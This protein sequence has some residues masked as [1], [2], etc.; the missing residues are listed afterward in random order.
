MTD[1]IRIPFEGDEA[2]FVAAA[3][4]VQK[5]M[6]S[7]DA[8]LKAAGVTQTAYNKAVSASVKATTDAKKAEDARLATMQKQMSS[9]AAV[10]KQK[11]AAMAAEEKANQAGKFSFTELKSAIDLAAQAMQKLK[12]G[13]D[14]AREGASIEFTAQKFDRLAQTI[15]T[16]GDALQDK[17]LVATKGTLSEMEAMASATDLISLG[18]VKTE[19]DT[20]RL[21]AVVAGLGMD[22]NQ[23][24]LALSN[25][26]TMRFDQ[27]GVAVVGF[28]EKVK[29]L[30][31]TGMSAQD[32]FTEA[33]LQ[34][35]EE[36]LLKVGNAADTSL[37]QFM[38]MEAAVKDLKVEFNQFAAALIAPQ[39]PELTEGLKQATWRVQNFAAVWDEMNRLRGEGFGGII[40]GL[41]DFNM[42][43]DQAEKNV[44][45]TQQALEHQ[46]AAVEVGTDRWDDMNTV[47]ATTTTQLPLTEEQ[48]KAVSEANSQFLGVL[49]NVKDAQEEFNEGMEKAR[50]EWHEG[51]IETEEYAAKVD[52]LRETYQEASAAIVMSIVEMKLAQDGWTNAELDAY[53]RIG[54]AQGVFTQGQVEM[55]KDALANADALIASSG[56]LGDQ[57]FHTGERAEDA[58]VGMGIMGD[59]AVG[60]QDDV[61]PATAA[62]GGL[63]SQLNGLPPSGSAWAY[64]FQINVSGQVPRL[65]SVAGG[66]GGTQNTAEI[67]DSGGTG[68]A[69]NVY[70]I[71]KGA[72]PEAFIPNTDGTF[73]PNADK[74]FGTRDDTAIIAAIERNRIDERRLARSIVTAMAQAGI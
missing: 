34:Q 43:Q 3:K 72:Q 5:E 12:Q 20:V 49:G 25:Q 56:D 60:L 45:E 18:L 22:M 50:I 48:L 32:A 23:L 59:A 4:K 70:M 37:G 30:E 31:K 57:I 39:L 41:D 9:F 51:K 2:D 17:L 16:T 53:L 65:P 1:P 8:K 40:M 61:R 38:K 15:G 13:Y 36:Q 58:A 27:L 66:A 71:G 10:Q 44:R 21:S 67:R 74:A 55:T 63:K 26:T 73:V 24:V 35:A 11:A 19:A 69:G 42:L 52:E 6:E 54:V 7:L 46:A 29:A 64:D 28:D 62:V 14:F 33:F 68:E 47:L